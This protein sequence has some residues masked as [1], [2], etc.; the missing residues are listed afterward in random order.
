MWL[1]TVHTSRIIYGI[2]Y[3][4][5]EVLYYIFIILITLLLAGLHLDGKTRDHVIIKGPGL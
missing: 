4:L 5:V 2:E 3:R 1:E